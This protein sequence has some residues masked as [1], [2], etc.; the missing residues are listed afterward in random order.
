MV[1]PRGNF[2]LLCLVLWSCAK[3]ELRPD[4]GSA[5]RAATLMVSAD[6]RG[7]LGPCGC[8][9]SMR[10][11][12]ERMARQ[13]IELRRTGRPVLYLDAGDSLFG[14]LQLEE[15]WIPQEERKAQAL[16]QVFQL[17]G[18]ATRAVGELDEARGAGFRRSLGLPEQETPLRLLELA[19]RQVAVVAAGSESELFAAARQAREARAS[20][21]LGLLHQDLQLAQRTAERAGL[22]ADLLVAG[23]ASG[24]LS[25]EESK[26]VR[27]ALPVAQ[28]QSKGRA[29]LRVELHFGG[30][31]GER[32]E[33][34]P[35][36]ADRERELSALEA[37]IELLRKEVNQL[38]PRPE[39]LAL[40]RAKLEELILRRQ[41]LAQAP[42]PPP[43]GKNAFTV[44][45]VP[46]ESSLPGLP[47]AEEV[48]RAHDREVARLNLEW[49]KERGQD[50]RA[51]KQGEAAFVG[52]E[53][54]RPCHQRA[55]P[56]WE[57]SKHA[58]AYRTLDEQGKAFRLDCVRCHLTG[59]GSPG[60]VCRVDQVEGRAEVGCESCHG[61]GS[62]HALR[63]K[64]ERLLGKPG[65]AECRH[66]HDAENSPHFELE[67]YLARVVA[68]GHG[69]GGVR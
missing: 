13:V 44:R 68:P 30:A 61:P 48:V 50:C 19:G 62:L 36:P 24:Q 54:C 67:Q 35:G 65:L 20:F 2:L 69:R 47:E 6:L 14:R 57:G 41:A 42:L 28:V 56:A 15:A 23:H 49:A 27:G 33:L 7:Y 51:P 3:K 45:F 31:E 10:G 11:G 17:M 26:L 64:A 52:S 46:L 63:P 37:R 22:E 8:A 43:E 5:P 55:F 18:I 12:I 32:F 4:A 21:V 25:G 59:M 16:A 39:A 60:G 1:T 29:L 9:A 34:L 40:R 53:A 38:A 66:C 58:R